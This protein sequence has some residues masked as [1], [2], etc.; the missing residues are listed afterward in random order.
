VTTSRRAQRREEDPEAILSHNLEAE[1]SV[2]GALMVRPDHLLEGAAD[3]R[4]EHFFRAA[5]ATIFET[6]QSLHARGVRFDLVTLKD[7]LATAGKLEAVGGPAYLAS[8][9]DGVPSSTNVEYYARVVRDHHVRRGLVLLAQQALR[10]ARES[11]TGIGAVNEVEA[12]LS[13]L[14]V[15]A[16]V[17]LTELL[18]PAALV[19][20]A[21][22]VIERVKQ[23]GRPVTGISTGMIDLDEK[24]RGLHP[25]QLIVVAARPGEGKSTLG[26]NIARRGAREGTVLFES[27]EMDREECGM[28]LLT[29]EAHV[30][31]HDLQTRPLADG[32]PEWQALASAQVSLDG[33]RL[34]VDDFPHRSVAQIRSIARRVQ[35]SRR[36]LKL[37]V[38]DY[39]GLLTPDR[40]R[41]EG[42]RNEEVADMTR[43]LK[44]LAKEL[45]IPIVL[46]VQLNRKVDE[47]NAARNHQTRR[48]R[49]ADLAESGAIEKDADVIVFI[50]IPDKDEPEAELIVAKN[51]RGPK[52]IVRVAYFEEQYRFADRARDE[53]AA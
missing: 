42:K 16:A 38:I 41:S 25:G 31:G 1:R 4:P 18:E 15:D 22:S 14:A 46:L 45:R 19:A 39:L 3:L 44:L 50:Y 24:L 37:I 43:A 48:P 27:L 7:A 40:R 13:Q 2:L 21:A 53:E 28:R 30:N 20:A 17:G 26:M 10:L 49:M 52:G 23:T 36:D 47:R 5:H 8:L 34:L 32:A 29:S 51:R 9:L 6:A 35:A 33:A 12:G 11:E